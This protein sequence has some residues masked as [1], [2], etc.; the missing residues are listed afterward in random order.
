VLD[1]VVAVKETSILVSNPFLMLQV[2]VLGGSVLDLVEVREASI[3]V[4]SWLH[5]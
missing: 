1:S 5:T 2:V 4:S 3:M